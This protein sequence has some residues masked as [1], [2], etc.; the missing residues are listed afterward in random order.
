MKVMISTVHIQKAVL[1]AIPK[2]SPE[3]IV[4][5]IDSN[6]LK[7]SDI[8]EIKKLYGQIMPIEVIKTDSYDIVKIA[9]D[10]V[11][12]IEE[13][14]SKGN[15]VV[16]HITEGRKTMAIA[17]MYA[18]YARKKMIKGIYYITE[19]KNELISLPVL[20]LQINS[21]K[22]TIMKQFAKGNSD[23][24]DLAKITGKTEAMVY[25]HISDLKEEGYISPD[26]K[27]TDSGRIAIL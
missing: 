10:V 22:G 24:K 17:S 20:E 6:S 23:I 18:A 25:A 2:L 7:T 4:F 3:K 19:E 9:S 27:L 11:K 13:E 12:K 26:N 1:A 15:E 16:I 14:N 8:S 21:T 5:L